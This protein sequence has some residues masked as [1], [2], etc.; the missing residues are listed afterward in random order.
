MPTTAPVPT[1]GYAEAVLGSRR[2]RAPLLLLLGRFGLH[3]WGFARDGPP[4]LFGRYRLGGPSSRQ[5]YAIHPCLPPKLELDA[6]DILTPYSHWNYATLSYSLD[7]DD[8][9]E[10]RE[11]VPAN[12]GRDAPSVFLR[13]SKLPKG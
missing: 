10:I 9:I 12:A 11:V 8:T 5:V 1:S 2:T 6:I 13:R 4:L 3:V 7:I